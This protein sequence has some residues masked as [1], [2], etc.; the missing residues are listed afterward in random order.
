[1]IGAD[2]ASK[3]EEMFTEEE[4]LAAISGLNGDKAPGP[5]GFPLVFWSFSWDFVKVE[6]LGFFREFFEHNQFVKSL[7]ATFLVL[8]PKGRTVENLKDLRPISLVGSLYKILSK[9]LAN[10]IKRVMGVIISHSQNAFVE[11]RQILDA[12][13]IANEAVDSILRRKEKGILCKLDIE[14]A[15]DHIRWDFLLQIMERMG[16][17][18]KWISWIKWC[19][20]TA[21]FSV[22]VNGSS[23][24]FFRSSRGLRQGDPLSPYLF[25]IGMEALCCMLKR[26]VEGNFISGCRF[27]G[28]DGGDIVISHLLYADDT[29]LFCEANS[30]QL[31]Y[32]RWTLMWFEAFSG[33]KINLIKSVIIPLGRV[34]NVEVLAVELGC[35]VGSL[36]STYLGLPLGAP[37][38]P[39]TR[40]PSFPLPFSHRN[41][42]PELYA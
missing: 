37:Q 31:M 10:R 32:L 17:G 6:V 42:S 2:Q 25:V 8:V 34:D 35:G 16:F 11:G 39:E 21:S 29:I 24:G 14:K 1:M 15:Y 36:P 12:V 40:G 30:E 38:R 19:I 7:N 27:S 22:L 20:F 3:L 9:V 5:D 26:V 13:L 41:G 18:S 4:I 28:R 33:L 23:T